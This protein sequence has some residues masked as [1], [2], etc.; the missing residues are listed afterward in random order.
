MVRAELFVKDAASLVASSRL[1]YSC[2]ARGV[3]LPNKQSAAKTRIS[4]AAALRSLAGVLS[5]EELSALC[6]HYSVKFNSEGRDRTATCA[7]FEEYLALAG[8]LN[9]G[10]CLLVSGSGPR[11]FDSLALLE[12]LGGAASKRPAIGVAFNPFLTDQM[13]ERSRLRRKLATG[14]VSSVWLQLGSDVAQ[15]DDALAFLG[16]LKRERELPQLRL[17]GS[18]FLPTRQLLAQMKFRP[19]SGVFLSDEFLSSVD[20]AT[21]ITRRVLSSYAAHGVEPLLESAIRS[22]ADWAA[23]LEQLGL[24]SSAPGGGVAPPTDAA[25]PLPAPQ[26]KRPRSAAAATTAA[27]P[28]SPPSSLVWYRSFDLR[29][30]DHEPLRA[31]ADGG[32]AVVPCFVWPSVRG[33]WS[34]GGAACAWLERALGSLDGSLRSHGSRLV[35]RRADAIE[36]DADAVVVSAAAAASEGVRLAMAASAALPPTRGAEGARAEGEAVATAAELVRL[37]RETGAATV[38][39]HKCYEPE[40]RRVDAVVETALTS[41]GVRA[42]PMAGHLLYE[43]S[44]V[45]LSPGWSGGHWGTLM[46]F[47]KASERSGPPPP[48]PSGPP[49]SLTPPPSWPDGVELSKLCLAPPPVRRD[50]TAGRDWAAAMMEG[51]ECSEV[52]AQEA[53]AAFVDGAGLPSYEARRSRADVTGSVSRLSPYLR[54]GQL[55]P[56]RLYHAV[57]DRGLP[58]DETKTFGRRLHWR[59]LASYQLAAFPEMTHKPIRAH[60]ESHEWSDDRAALRAWQTGRTGYPMVD[61]GMRCLYATGWMHQSV[62]M[63]CAAFLVEYLGI[64]WVEGARWFHD[65]LVDADVAI[66]SMMWQNAGRSGIDQWNFVP[67]P[68]SGSQDASGHYCRRWCPELAALPTKHIHTPWKASP[69][70][71]AAAGVKLGANYPE[72]I[73]V[74]LEAARRGTVGALL[75]MRRGA[76]QFN[77]A[78]GYDIITLPSGTTTRVFTKEE[79]RIGADGATP[80]ARGRGRGGGRGKGRKSGGGG[81]GRSLLDLYG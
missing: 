79:Y 16:E 63:V 66:N 38:L 13:S 43:P 29:L 36:P 14:H 61:A 71:L 64:S 33:E 60:Y 7:K 1:L 30:S 65:T 12:A 40:G 55:A 46:P 4:P 80:A 24:S 77:D 76:P 73:V 81:R 52:A 57:R 31:A 53:M 44:Q 8:E 54:F 75:R 10:E 3:N 32:G 2:G 50:G 26:P 49:S 17:Y 74:D 58:R 18:V 9:V 27:A 78:G 59:D 42:V 45:V 62:R 39:W 41:A 25:D 6:P 68:V 34:P 48:R 20:A 11:A 69:E 23:A 70:T 22:E 47:L 72:R 19:W 28:T 35:L 37:A 67:S 21:A 5:A 51:W 15:L 56:R